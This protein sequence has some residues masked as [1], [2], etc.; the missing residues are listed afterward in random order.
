MLVQID[1]NKYTLTQWSQRINHSSR[2]HPTPPVLWI[3]QN[4]ARVSS[5]E[6]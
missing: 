6:C 3:Q 1:L 2:S 5:T 4:L